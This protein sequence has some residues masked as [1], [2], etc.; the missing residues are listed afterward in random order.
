VIVSRKDGRVLG[1]IVVLDAFLSFY[2]L[3]QF[4]RTAHQNRSRSQPWFFCAYQ[5]HSQQLLFL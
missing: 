5:S 1:M 3:E 4:E 2:E